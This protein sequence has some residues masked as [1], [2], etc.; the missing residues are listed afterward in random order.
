MEWKIQGFQQF[1]S[2]RL[3]MILLMW[4]KRDKE[5]ATKA[6]N[7]GRVGVGGSNRIGRWG[8]VVIGSKEAAEKVCSEGRHFM[9]YYSFMAVL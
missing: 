5:E 8:G 6:T 2:D 1:G 7:G 9:K 3:K 4:K